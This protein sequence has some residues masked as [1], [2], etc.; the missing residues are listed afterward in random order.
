MDFAPIAARH[1]KSKQTETEL[2]T[3]KIK[4]HAKIKFIRNSRTK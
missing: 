4:Y 2:I 3:N 1:H